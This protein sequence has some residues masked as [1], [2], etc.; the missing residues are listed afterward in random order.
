MRRFPLLLAIAC[1]AVNVAAQTV[2]TASLPA[3]FKH[4]IPPTLNGDLALVD[5]TNRCDGCEPWRY[6]DF[7][8][9]TS[10][11]PIKRERVSVIAGYRAM[12]AYP[13]TEYFANVKVEQSAAGQFEVDRR[14]M[15]EA[16]HSEYRRKKERID[17]YFATNPQVKERAEANRLKGRDYIELEEGMRNGI[18]YVS[19]VENVVGLTGATISQVHFFVPSTGISVTAYLIKQQRAKFKDIQEFRSLRQEFIDGYSAF[20]ASSGGG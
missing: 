3:V 16:I 2:T 1:A 14:I 10:A 17:T 19:Y 9:N 4:A 5:L 13:G 18:S 20:L 15:E 12:Y 7:H 11:E 6:I 8:S